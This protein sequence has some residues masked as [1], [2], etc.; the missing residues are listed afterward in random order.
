MAGASP[1]DGLISYPGHSLGL[2]GSYPSAEMQSMYSTAPADWAEI[3]I[4]YLKPYN[5]VQTNDNYMIEIIN[6]NH[7]I[8]SIR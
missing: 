4:S 6:W 8:I 1:L 7:I 2:G 3:I 5:S